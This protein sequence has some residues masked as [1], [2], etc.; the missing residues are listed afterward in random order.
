MLIVLL[1]VLVYLFANI[2]A[3]LTCALAFATGEHAL[4]R[5]V[6][7]FFLAPGYVAVGFACFE[8]ASNEQAVAGVLLAIVMWCFAFAVGQVM[9]NIDDHISQRSNASMSA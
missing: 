4:S 6:P 3:I 8:L 1:C 5:G 7:W 2:L 9:R